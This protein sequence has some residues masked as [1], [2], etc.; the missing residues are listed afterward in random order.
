[1]AWDE[2][3][4]LLSGIMPDTPLGNVVAIRSEKDHKVIKQFTPGQREIYRSW[5]SRLA[6]RLLANENDLDNSMESLTLMLKKMFGGEKNE[7]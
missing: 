2:F 4:A 1:M 5:Q 3:S 6:N 7:R